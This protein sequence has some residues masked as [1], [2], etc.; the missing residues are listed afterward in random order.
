[1]IFLI[2]VKRV[3]FLFVLLLLACG[4]QVFGQTCCSGGVPLSG[5][6]GMP[7][8]SQGTWQFS[9]SYDL[10][11]LRTLKDGTMALD[12]HAR[13]RI[14]QSILLQSGYSIS[15]RLS[16]D[17]FFSYVK[18]ERTIRQFDNTDYVATDGIGDAA[19]LIKYHLTDITASNLLLTLATGPK[20]P[21]GRSDFRR[22][23]GIPLNADLQPGS[24]AWDGIF[25]GNGIYKFNFRPSFNVS[26]TIIYSLKG[27]NNHYLNGQQYQFGNEFQAI[28]SANDN[29]VL[30]KKLLDTSLIIRYR[31]ALSDRFN[32]ETMP[33]T[34]G[35]WIFIA[36]SFAYNIS[37]NLSMTSNAEL[38]LYANVTGTQ[39]SPTYR[40]NFGLLMKINRKNEILKL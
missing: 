37:Q 27:K 38:P 14:T 33:S 7:P 31:E 3:L 2:M 40:L 1:M 32:D 16:A 19:V 24:G 5:N 12:D 10:N 15:N 4:M 20:I 11:V 28:F 35:K 6:L 13:E 22:Q 34:G 18:Q 9:M 23:D 36:P 39:L 8:G 17:L 29:F 25:W 21:T 26:G 30:G